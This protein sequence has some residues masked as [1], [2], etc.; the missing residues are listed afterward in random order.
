MLLIDQEQISAASV[1]DSRIVI[2]TSV[3]PTMLPAKPAKINSADRIILQETSKRRSSLPPRRLQAIQLTKDQKPEDPQELER[4]KKS[5]GR[6]E[7][8]TDERGIPVG[9]YRV[10]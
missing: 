10:W 4:I 3:I 1:G 5:G 9:P 6:V 7:R 8:L 2:A